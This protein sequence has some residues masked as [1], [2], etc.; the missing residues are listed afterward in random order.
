M[1]VLKIWHQGKTNVTACC[2]KFN[3][4]MPISENYNLHEKMGLVLCDKCI[5][6]QNHFYWN[7]QFKTR[8][9]QTAFRSFSLKH[10]EE[11]IKSG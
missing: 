7:L 5:L 2:T 1:E 4:D 10:P 9:C 11:V 6:K 8:T 3:G